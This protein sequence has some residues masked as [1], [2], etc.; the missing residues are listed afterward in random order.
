MAPKTLQ[1][2]AKTYAFVINPLI[3]LPVFLWID[4][5]YDNL[6]YIGNALGRPW[7]LFLWAVSSC[8]GMYFFARSIWKKYRIAWNTAFHRLICCGMPFS[9]II[10]YSDSLPGIIN[11]L[12][13]W[14]AVVCVG[15]YIF[16]WIR[17]MFDPVFTTLGSY[18][19]LCILLLA[20]FAASFLCMSAA[21]HVNALCEVS[22]SVL[23]NMVL[24]CF[25]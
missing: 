9:C 17:T 22:F 2:L 20:V 10:P 18:H 7:Y 8:L 24:S 13:V 1:T 23:V 21:G 14:I 4:P 3:N 12:H 5:A 6:S 19:T 15:L 16:E 11:D 25:V